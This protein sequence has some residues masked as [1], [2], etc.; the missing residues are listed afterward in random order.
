MHH[1]PGGGEQKTKKVDL[2]FPSKFFT[3]EAFPIG[4]TTGPRFTKAVAC[5]TPMVQR[6]GPDFPKYDFEAFERPYFAAVGPT[7]GPVP[8]PEGPKISTKLIRCLARPRN[9]VSRGAR[10]GKNPLLP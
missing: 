1:F 10:G 4:R 2:P 5:G 6:Y 7:E 3:P 8:V 9:I